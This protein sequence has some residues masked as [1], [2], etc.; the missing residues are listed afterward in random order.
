MREKCLQLVLWDGKGNGIRFII[1][2]LINTNSNLPLALCGLL[3][4]FFC[5]ITFLHLVQHK[6]LQV[7]RS[8]K[9]T[10]HRIDLKNFSRH[11]N[12]TNP[13]FLQNVESTFGINNE[14]AGIFIFNLD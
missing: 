8:M 3:K 10:L 12:P 4:S 11:I 1:S 14:E 13:Y 9:R 7:A 2:A 5:T 6:T